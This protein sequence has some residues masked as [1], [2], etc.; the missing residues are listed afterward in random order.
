VAL[1]VTLE[2]LR[3]PRTGRR[4]GRGEGPRFAGEGHGGLEDGERRS[5]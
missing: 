4:S 1:V 2:A 5:V 3:S